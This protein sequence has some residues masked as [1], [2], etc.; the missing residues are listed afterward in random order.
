SYTLTGRVGTTEVATL[1]IAT[2]GAY[3]FTLQQALDHSNPTLEDILALGFTVTA[4]DALNGTSNTTLVINVEDDSPIAQPDTTYVVDIISP[5]QEGELVVSYGADHGYVKSITLDGY[6]LSYSQA[7]D[8]ITTSGTAGLMTYSF[9][10]ASDELTIHTGAGEVL[11]VDMLTGHYSYDTEV[12]EQAPIV[13]INNSS[14]LLGLVS[15]DVLNLVQIGSNQL[16]TAVDPNNDIQSVT[17]RYSTALSV[18]LLSPFNLTWSQAIASEFGLSISRTN[19]FALLVQTYSQIV[20]TA[21]DGGTIDN[22][23]LN[24]FLA[25]VSLNSLLDVSVLPTLSISATDSSGKTSTDSYTDLVGIGL[26]NPSN[27]TAG[28]W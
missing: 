23:K 14:S 10:A 12:V 18:S 28:I 3:T 22:L 7:T 20:I 4:L 9:D 5:A 1:T 24:E 15:T 26:L 2:S 11:V 8:S 27:N 21:A 17:V 25:T 6:T 16:L 19:D 13:G